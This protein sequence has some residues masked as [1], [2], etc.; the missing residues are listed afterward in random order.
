[1]CAALRNCL[2]LTEWR[3]SIGYIWVDSATQFC[4]CAGKQLQHKLWLG[5]EAFFENV[6]I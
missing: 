6:D 5:F 4:V 2:L 1:M 3:Y